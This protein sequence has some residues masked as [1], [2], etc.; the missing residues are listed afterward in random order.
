MNEYLKF[1]M[2]YAISFPM[3]FLLKELFSP[4]VTLNEVSRF[5][6]PLYH[7]YSLLTISPYF[8]RHTSPCSMQIPPTRPYQI[9]PNTGELFSNYRCSQNYLFASH[10]S[11]H[12]LPRPSSNSKLTPFPE[13]NSE[14]YLLL[15]TCS[16][17][18]NQAIFNCT[19]FEYISANIHFRYN[20]LVRK[21]TGFF[22][23]YNK[24]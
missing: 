5:H 20:N 22:P 4:F 16:S 2:N 7:D 21:K 6:R 17:N 23:S 15:L 11:P 10:P 13:I 18:Q 19:I 9:L 1:D 24:Q 8:S 14:T 12:I 3:V